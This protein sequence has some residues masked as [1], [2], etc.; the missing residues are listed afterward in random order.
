MNAS[1]RFPSIAVLCACTNWL[2]AA[3]AP[4]PYGAVPHERQ[5]AWQR[6]E[7]YG[8]VHFG[9]NTWT[10]REWGY[11]DEDPE[12]FNPSSFDARASVRIF[13]DAGL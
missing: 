5:L 2:P 12:L 13:K 11:G 1:F 9:L 6:L 7:Y 8:F 3:T 4:A 10:D